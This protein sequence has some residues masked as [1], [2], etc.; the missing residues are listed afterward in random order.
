MNIVTL[1]DQTADVDADPERDPGFFG[2]V[3]VA[4]ADRPLTVKRVG[5]R[6]HGAWNLK[7]NSVALTNPRKRNRYAA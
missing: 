5:R 1:D 7:Q 6:V 4:A 3:R 2:N